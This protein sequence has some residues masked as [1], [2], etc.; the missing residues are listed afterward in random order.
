LL[1]LPNE[2]Y[3]SK[4]NKHFIH[5]CVATRIAQLKS[6]GAKFVD[7]RY[8]ILQHILNKHKKEIKK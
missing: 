7:R 5:G 6:I 4:S 3:G 2:L 1:L 8:D